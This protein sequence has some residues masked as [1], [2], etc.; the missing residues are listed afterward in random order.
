MIEYLISNGWKY[1]GT[2]NCVGNPKKYKKG[3]FVIKVYRQRWEL[4]ND[5][6]GIIA[7][8]A[9]QLREGLTNHM[10]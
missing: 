7:G 1:I 9:D 5:G 3:L 10:K 8:K 6:R 4:Y 2:C